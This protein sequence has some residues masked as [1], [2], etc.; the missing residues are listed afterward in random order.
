MATKRREPWGELLMTLR[1]YVRHS[2]DHR[3]PAWR[4]R[5]RKLLDFLLVYIA[6]GTG[7]F[8]IDG[9]EYDARPGDLF[10]IPPDTAH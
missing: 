2:G 1:P 6:D 8:I 3:R 4:I 9:V 7:R 10:W 5:S